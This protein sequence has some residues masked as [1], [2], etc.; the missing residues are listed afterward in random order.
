MRKEVKCYLKI[1]KR[2]ERR[3]ENS[4]HNEDTENINKASNSGKRNVNNYD[5]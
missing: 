4:H 2:N 5:Y 3:N 1:D